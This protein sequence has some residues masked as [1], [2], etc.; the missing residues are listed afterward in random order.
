MPML[1]PEQITR[2][3][4]EK[5]RYLLSL[6]LIVC[7]NGF[8]VMVRNTHLT[9]PAALTTD[10]VCSIA[11]LAIGMITTWRLCRAIRI[12][13][14]WTAVVTLLSPVSFVIE[15]IVL[16]RIYAKRTGLRLTFLMGDRDPELSKAA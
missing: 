5:R 13:I 10:R 9:S 1:D 4:L 16:F 8:H 6:L 11:A 7:A 3:R 2:A 12:G 15:M 14:G